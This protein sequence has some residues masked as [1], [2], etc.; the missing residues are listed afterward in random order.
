MINHMCS[1]LFH[2]YSQ[3]HERLQHRRRKI[4]CSGF[5]AFENA[6]VMLKESYVYNYSYLSIM[7][8]NLFKYFDTDIWETRGYLVCRSWCGRSQICFT[9]IPKV[10]M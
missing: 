5:N 9:Y 3:Q 8:V 6:A 7:Q 2:R 10:C 4:C 1:V